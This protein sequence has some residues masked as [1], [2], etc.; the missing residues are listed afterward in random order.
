MPP[1]VGE[2][3]FNGVKDYFSAIARST[4]LPVMVQNMPFTNI[5]LSIDNVIELCSLAPNISWVKQ[6]TPP[7]PSGVE[8]LKRK[9]TPDVEGYMSGYSG[10]YSLQDHANGATATIH[11][12]QFCDVMQRIWDLLDE[13]RNDEARELHSVLVPALVLEGIYTWQY[14]KIIMEKRGIFKNHI[15]RNKSNVITESAMKEFD[16]IWDRVKRMV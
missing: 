12:A 9:M 4:S 8:E 1:Y 13:G 15:T 14:T 16:A 2:L 10:I 6:E 5:S 11:A 7:A 3:N